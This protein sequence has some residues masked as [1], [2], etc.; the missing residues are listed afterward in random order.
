MNQ[1]NFHPRGM[2]L[3]REVPALKVSAAIR[4]I[5]EHGVIEAVVA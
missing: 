3:G 5:S 1:Q 2:G 4:R